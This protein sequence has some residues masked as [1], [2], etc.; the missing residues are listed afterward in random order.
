MQAR[1][2]D[3][4][5]GRF[6]SIDLV[7]FLDNGNP[8]MF[9]R[10]GYTF[11]DPINNFD[12]DG[13]ETV[14]GFAC[15]GCVAFGGS[16]CDGLHRDV[17]KGEALPQEAAGYASSAFPIGVGA[18][19]GIGLGARA[20]GPAALRCGASKSFTGAAN[21]INSVTSAGRATKGVATLRI[22]TG[23]RSGAEKLF[24]P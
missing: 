19:L 2:Y 14:S 24:K 6:L 13:R 11:N 21:Y 20:L 7:T 12:P 18:R 1:Y 23:G 17:I 5:A 3:A 4:V 9:N 10:Y 16:D 8:A 22:G 15:T